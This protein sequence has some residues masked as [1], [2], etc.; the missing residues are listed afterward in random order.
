[1][2]VRSKNEYPGANLWAHY[3][4][5]PN[6]LKYCGP[7]ANVEL[8]EYATRKISDKGLVKILSEFEAAFPYIQF[9]AKEN[10]HFYFNV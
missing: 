4:F 8:F 7:D 9:I 10:R 3:S 1:M 6:H 2:P 5:A